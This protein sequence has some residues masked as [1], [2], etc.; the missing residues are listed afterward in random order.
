MSNSK[1]TVIENHV[2]E[3]STSNLFTPNC[4]DHVVYNDKIYH[5]TAAA[6]CGNERSIKLER[7]SSGE[8][9]WLSGIEI[10]DAKIILYP[11]F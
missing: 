4:G 2:V 9:I 8:E 7:S 3:I 1:Q 5:V 10:K 6:G 11:K